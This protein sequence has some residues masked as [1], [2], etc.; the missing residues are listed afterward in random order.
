MSSRG[1]RDERRRERERAQ[2]ASETLEQREQRLSLRHERDVQLGMPLKQLKNSSKETGLGGLRE[3]RET[4]GGGSMKELK[5]LRKLQN[6]ENNTTEGY[7]TCAFPTLFPMGNAD[8][9]APRVNAVSIG[10]YFKH[11]MMVHTRL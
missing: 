11:L 4:R 1:E 7:M 9:S 3:E 6:R 10:S 2:R 8:F 5:E